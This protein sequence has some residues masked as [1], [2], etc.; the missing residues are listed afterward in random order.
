MTGT[1]PAVAS[2]RYRAMTLLVSGPV[3]VLTAASLW[4]TVGPARALVHDNLPALVVGGWRQL[5][6]GAVLLVPV[7]AR[8]ARPSLLRIG[9]RPAVIVAAAATGVYQILFLYAVTAVGAGLATAVA[10]GVAP[11]ATG[12]CSWLWQRV[13]PRMLWA[14]STAI[15]AAGT[16]LLLSGA[17]SGPRPGVLGLLAA[18]GAGL[19]YGL[20]TVAASTTAATEGIDMTAVAAVTLLLGA[21]PC[22][23]AMATHAPA[24]FHPAPLLLLLWLGVVTSG[25]AYWSFMRGMKSTTASTAGTLSLAEP[26]AAVCLSVVLLGE[27]LSATQITGCALVTLGLAVTATKAKRQTNRPDVPVADNARDEP[28]AASRATARP[29]RRC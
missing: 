23:P 15:C 27:K 25:A 4:G 13:R 11:A 28:A 7:M 17:T 5:L 29:G 19:C 22:L 18:R 6:G 2:G 9:C 10:L 8:R 14:V 12:L 20:Y 21:L 16:T 26:V 3:L 1:L 24:I